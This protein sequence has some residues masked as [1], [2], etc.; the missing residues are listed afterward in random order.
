MGRL[1]VHVTLPARNFPL[2]VEL[3]AS[4]KAPPPVDP[5][6]SLACRGPSALYLGALAWEILLFP[7]QAWAYR[8]IFSCH[9]LPA[10]APLLA[11]TTYP[12]FAP[13]VQGAWSLP[14]VAG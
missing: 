8:Q 10:P 1:N 12:D 3:Y 7:F 2:F 14:M 13:L 6:G 11:L 9:A 4:Y 5:L